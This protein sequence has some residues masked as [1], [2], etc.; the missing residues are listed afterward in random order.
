MS[1]ALYFPTMLWFRANEDS[2]TTCYHYTS[3]FLAL[4]KSSRE[5]SRL[6]VLKNFEISRNNSNNITIDDKYMHQKKH[7]G[8]V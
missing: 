1:S 2:E 7:W 5:N 6:V 4:V 8:N 3:T